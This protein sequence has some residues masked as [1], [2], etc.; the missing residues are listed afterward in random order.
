MPVWVHFMRQ[1][2]RD[3]PEA[4]IAAPDGLVTVKISPETGLLASADDP[5]AMFE[6]FM[7]GHLPE[8]SDP[9][10]RGQ[11]ASRDQPKDPMSPC[12][13]GSRRPGRP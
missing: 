4:L 7:E 3:T 10:A 5:S 13:E 1:A 8:S 11:S 12:S 6:T 9:F 2:L